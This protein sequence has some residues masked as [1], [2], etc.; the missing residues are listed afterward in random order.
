MKQNQH[1]LNIE[2]FKSAKQ[3][4]RLSKFQSSPLRKEKSR[5]SL[6]NFDIGINRLKN[7]SGNLRRISSIFSFSSSPKKNKKS[8][9]QKMKKLK[10][11]LSAFKQTENKSNLQHKMDFFY[12][13][14]EIKHTDKLVVKK[15][16]RIFS[17]PRIQNS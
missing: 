15:K 2:D 8:K 9:W 6:L 14:Y 3:A 11:M 10:K 5:M 12:K 7:C 4:P 16:T 1:I 17:L 13:P